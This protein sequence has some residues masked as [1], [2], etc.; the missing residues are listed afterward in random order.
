MTEPAKAR[1]FQT[2][3]Q[4]KHMVAEIHNYVQTDTHTGAHEQQHVETTRQLAI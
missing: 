1:Q 4:Q 2:G 3:K